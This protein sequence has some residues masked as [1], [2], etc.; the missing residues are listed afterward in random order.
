[1]VLVDCGICRWNELLLSFHAFFLNQ[2]IA[3]QWTSHINGSSKL[4]QSCN[5]FF[6]ITNY[7][8]STTYWLRSR[9]YMQFTPNSTFYSILLSSTLLLPNIPHRLTHCSCF[10]HRWCCLPLPALPSTG[11]SDATANSMLRGLLSSHSTL[12][13]S[14]LQLLHCHSLSPPR[15]LLPLE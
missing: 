14:S 7:L 13:S 15:S 11:A 10:H 8:F 9:Q 3:Y 6:I 4:H 1:M 5:W 2:P 12:H